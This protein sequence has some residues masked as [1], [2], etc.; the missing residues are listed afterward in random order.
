MRGEHNKPGTT[1]QLTI[2]GMFRVGS[3]SAGHSACGFP[4]ETK[5]VSPSL[6]RAEWQKL[7]AE[8]T[9]LVMEYRSRKGYFLKKE[10]GS[11]RQPIGGVRSDEDE[12]QRSRALHACLVG[13]TR[14]SHIMTTRRGFTLIELLAVIAIL[15]LLVALLMPGVQSAREAARR[16][17][18]SNNMKQQALGIS[19]FLQANNDYFPAASYFM[20]GHGSSLWVRLLPYIEYQDL[21]S[22]LSPGGNF[23]LYTTAYNQTDVHAGLLNNLKV[24]SY[25]C[26]SSPFGNGFNTYDRLGGTPARI[27]IQQG[28]YAPI[29][30]AIDGT[31][32]DHTNGRGP[33]A[34]SGVFAM[35]GL[36]AASRNI[37][38]PAAK[39]VDGLS[40]TLM[41]GEQSDFSVNGK[42]EI[43]PTTE[44]WMG[45]N[46]TAVA[47]NNGSYNPVTSDSGRC[48]NMTTVGFAINM[49]SVVTPSSGNPGSR[50]ADCNTPIQSAHPG[51]AMVS[52]ADGAVRFLSETLEKQTLFDLANGN[53]R[54]ATIVD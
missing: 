24:P 6:A 45:K 54:K 50:L 49:K 8:V 40:N 31:P 44:V 47:T 25:S 20:S 30:G 14:P 48:F 13:R 3:P 42:D 17:S 43:R 32:R 7:S 33:V 37:G 11:A 15:G 4:G 41:V 16:T 52:L 35:V 2:Y 5:A 9:C 23:Y 53:D 22:R 46:F 18:C 51:G 34:G 29:C 27:S 21:F 28:T 10:F 12:S 38:R 36:D 1:R 19:N 26:P 39:I